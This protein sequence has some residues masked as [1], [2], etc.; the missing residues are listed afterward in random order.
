[1]HPI[2]STASLKQVPLLKQPLLGDLICGLQR[3]STMTQGQF[4]AIGVS[5][6]TARYWE[7]NRMQ[8]SESALHQVQA[9]IERLSQ[10]TSRPMIGAKSFLN[11]ILPN[12]KRRA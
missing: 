4:A 8:P 9:L 5:D 10:S 2:I 7:A 3:L 1:M 11:C 6:V 12:C